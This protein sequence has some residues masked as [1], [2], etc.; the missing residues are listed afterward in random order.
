MFKIINFRGLH[1]RLSAS[2]MSICLVPLVILGVV[3]YTQAKDTI[4]EKFKVTSGQTITEINKMID[5]Y[6][7]T[8]MVQLKL[9]SK[10]IESAYS[11]DHEKYISIIDESLEDISN[12]NNNITSAFVEIGSESLITFPKSK[13]KLEDTYNKS[14]WYKRA[15]ESTGT[16]LFSGPTEDPITGKKVITLSKALL[17]NGDVIGV[18]G[19]NIS[20]QNLDTVFGD[21]KIGNTGY[22]YITNEDGVIISHTNKSLIGTDEAG[23]I[24]VWSYIRAN[25]LGFTEYQYKGV[26]KYAAF[27]TSNTTGWRVVGVMEQNEVKNDIN[28]LTKATLVTISIMALI[29]LV[30]AYFY[31]RNIAKNVKN[32]SGAFS[33]ASDGDLT[34]RV[35]IESEDEFNAL[36]DDFNS[37]ME[38][39]ADLMRDVKKSSKVVFET[40]SNLSIISAETKKSTSMV[41][42]SIKEISTGANE[43]AFSAHEGANCMDNLAKDIEYITNI[44]YHLTE[45]SNGAVDFGEKG[46]SI[47]K[48]LG[49]K[50]DKT[51]EASDE[52]SR[53]IGDM[54]K[55]IEKIS[56]ISNTIKDITD[57]TNLLSLNAGIEAERA[58]RAGAGF[59]VVATEIRKL[60]DKSK[61]ATLEI[62]DI[63]ESIQS[64]SV[65]TNRAIAESN[66]LIKQQ[67]LAV[68]ETEKVF[69]DI[70]KAI[71]NLTNKVHDIRNSAEIMVCKKVEVVDRIKA[72]D[73][74][75][76]ETALA[77]L[78]V[79]VSTTQIN[80]AIKGIVE[81]VKELDGL[82]KN[83]K[84][85]MNKFI[86]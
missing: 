11:G 72:I 65:E 50:S 6:F 79:S 40:S 31:S 60:A 33:K 19:V 74:V 8:D 68:I 3:N 73:M 85:E 69:I 80:N 62:R 26:D 78:E 4:S 53:A 64:M 71:N 67:D 5:Y 27:G 81:S 34:A 13:I 41:S 76:D 39:I 32:L 84:E 86:L 28:K 35:K 7:S 47:V 77:A 10:K 57:Q 55:G 54:S 46:L 14:D 23:K 49:E 63:T 15:I 51:K 48:N 18:I 59:A 61:K 45:V 83:L 44:T 22:V 70:L 38:N 2:L 42:K 36:G 58:G 66:E 29:T 56:I 17:I 24:S 9:T 30:I 43:Q 16:I 52:V 21:L 20:L 25:N 75:S 12:T 82:A 1:F 37:M